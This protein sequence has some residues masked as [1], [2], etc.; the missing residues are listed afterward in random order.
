[1]KFNLV[2]DIDESEIEDYITETNMP[3]KAVVGL[4]GNAC[5]LGLDCITAIVLR[6]LAIEVNDT[7]VEEI[8]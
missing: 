3:H 5:I 2:V 1:M 7:Y 8:K 6:Q 4:I